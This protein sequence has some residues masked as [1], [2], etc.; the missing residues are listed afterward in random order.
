MFDYTDLNTVIKLQRDNEGDVRDMRRQSKEAIDFCNK[1]DG[2]WESSVVHKWRGRPRYTDDRTNPIINQIVGEVYQANFT[3]R[4][5]PAGGDSTKDTAK[6]L[7]G[8]LRSIRNKSH[9][10]RIINQTARRVAI[11][12]IGGWEIIKDYS[13]ANSFNMDLMIQPIEDFHERVL[14]DPDCTNPTAEDA[15]WA[16]IK[17]YIGKN[18]FL[19]KFGDDKSVT[20]LGHDDW[21]DSYY[22]KPENITIGQLY[23]LKPVQYEIML[24]SDGSVYKVD[25]DLEAVLDELDA[26]G[27]STVSTR[28]V[29]D[30]KCCQRWY[31]ATEWLTDEEELDFSFVPVIT[32][33]G[34]FE[35][36]EGKVTYFGAV[37]RLMDIQRVHNYAFSRNVEEVALS[38]RSKWFMTPEQA[39]GFTE[40]L[41]TLNT[42]MDPVQFYNHI[43]DQPPPYF[44]N[45]SQ[46]NQAIL[47]L[48]QATDDGINKAAGIFAANIG[49]NPNV[50]S[51]VAIQEQIDR[52]NNGTAWLFEA[53]QMSIERTCQC[54]VQAI[55][56]CYDDTREVILMQDDGS[57]ETATI[58]QPVPD[59]QTGRT[60]FLNDITQ[61]QYDVTIDIGAAYKNRQKESVDA[62][63]RLAQSDPQLME[64][65]RDIHLN[66]I[67]APNMDLMAERA[68]AV[69]LN[70]GVIPQEQMTDEEVAQMQEAQAQAANQPPEADPQMIALEIEQ[71]KAQTAMMDQQNRQLQ[72]Q[73]RMHELQMNQQ[74]AQQKLES[75]LAVKSAEIEQGQQKIEI[76][77][78]ESQIKAS[79]AQADAVKQQSDIQQQASKQTMEYNQKMQELA[80]K[81]AELESK[82]G[83][84]MNA[85][86]QDNMQTLIF[87]PETGEIE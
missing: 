42:N 49:D 81:M 80:I 58:N 12:G 55:P 51:G 56:T 54:L 30:F 7:D 66:N 10:D 6:V 65:G 14:I 60:V 52:G 67:D 29:D 40:S 11:S 37:E 4:V 82:L 17:H 68:R 71:M 28:S 20:S 18:A 57:L 15:K 76:Q 23:Y 77:K 31:S 63:E 33:Y 35:V 85:Q 9:F 32:C 34:N 72:H 84:D 87:N 2:Q 25:D 86:V 61:G 21:S 27:I 19:D 74:G 39:A 73:V 59:A 13:E 79:K 1:R 36:S 64:L 75:D 62:F 48:Q 26:A 43:G 3:G 5:R 53:L 22:H 78:M 45:T 83:Q 38:P 50:Q 24:M 47:A 44:S 16:I 46:Q 70:N 69:M 8:L 41:S